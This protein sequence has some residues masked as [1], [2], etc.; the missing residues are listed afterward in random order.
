MNQRWPS[1]LVLLHPFTLLS[2]REDQQ[3]TADAS[4]TSAVSIVVWNS[5]AV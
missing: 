1:A 2:A 5:I 4:Y 3:Q